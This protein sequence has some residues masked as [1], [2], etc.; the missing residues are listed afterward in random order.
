MSN[1]GR[2]YLRAYLDAKHLIAG[3]AREIAAQ[4]HLQ[5]T[6]AVNTADEPDAG[7]I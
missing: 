2:D 5:A 1:S 3:I 7:R 4:H 6:V